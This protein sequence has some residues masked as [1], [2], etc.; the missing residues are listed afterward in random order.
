[1]FILL[2]IAWRNIWRNPR[3][4]WVLVWAVTFGLWMGVFLTAFYNGLIE[5]RI[6]LAINTESSHIQMHHPLFK[7]DYEIKHVLPEFASILQSLNEISRIQSVTSRMVIAGLAASANGSTGVVIQGVSPESEHRVTKLCQ[8]LTSGVCLQE[9]N[10]HSVMISES[11]AKKLKL[12]TGRKLV[13]SFTDVNGEIN[14]AALKISGL[15]QTNNGP[16]DD[17]NIF[18]HASM[19]DTLRNIGAQRNEIAIL[20]QSSEDLDQ[21]AAILKKKYPGLK[22]ETWK[23][24]SPELGLTVSVGDQMV[25]IFMGIILLAL[26]FG[27]INTM[28]MA[29]LER[30][31][32]IG[33]LMAIGM[34]KIRLFFMI[35][36]ETSMLVALGAPPGILLG[37]RTVAFFARKGIDLSAYTGLYSNFGYASTVYPHISGEK[38]V[39]VLFMLVAASLISSVFPAWRSLRTQPAVAI[40]K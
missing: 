17:T 37:L 18:V 4:S 40:K 26:V 12:K 2:K 23:E 14:S 36:L 27:I 6:A 11:L 20:L 34:N 38:V 32:E 24:I 28:M 30:T 3:R 15:Y 22:T 29:M 39:Q 19:L 1:M 25:F 16:Y 13:I 5:Q 31:R 10:L 7:P 9:G 35:V 8:K 21:T 33:I